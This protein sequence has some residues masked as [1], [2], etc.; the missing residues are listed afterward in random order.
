MRRAAASVSATVIYDAVSTSQGDVHWHSDST[1]KTSETAAEMNTPFPVDRRSSRGRLSAA[2][3]DTVPYFGA[4][5]N[6]DRRTHRY[7]ATHTGPSPSVTLTCSASSIQK[8][9][10]AQTDAET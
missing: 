2:A 5:A 4:R 1:V 8:T 6:S 3:V 10:R 7:R 9:T